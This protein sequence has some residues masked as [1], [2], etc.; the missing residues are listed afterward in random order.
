LTEFKVVAR[1]SFFLNT[2]ITTSQ[3][4]GSAMRSSNDRY[5]RERLCLDDCPARTSAI[6]ALVQPLH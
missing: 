5:S 1:G 6:I 3:H 4:T 2:A